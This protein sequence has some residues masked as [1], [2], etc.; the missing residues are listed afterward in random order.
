MGKIR[1]QG[2]YVDVYVLHGGFVTIVIFINFWSY[3]L[4]S[5]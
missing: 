4:P 1:H 5:F 2:V 3:Y